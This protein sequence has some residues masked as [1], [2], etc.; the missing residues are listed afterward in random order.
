M[1]PDK[2]R[3]CA[4]QLAL[5]V[6]RFQNRDAAKTALWAL[7]KQGLL[8]PDH[9]TDIRTDLAAAREALA[10]HMDAPRAREKCEIN[11]RGVIAIEQYLAHA[12]APL[13][14]AA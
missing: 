7:S 14:R 10:K 5:V 4:T 9:V 11:M 6:A 3:L 1:A 12:T 2:I 8:G 13:K